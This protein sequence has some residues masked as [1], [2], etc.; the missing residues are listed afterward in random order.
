MPVRFRPPSRRLSSGR[1][2]GGGATV[3]FPGGVVDHARAG[4]V[5]GRRSASARPRFPPFPASGFDARSG[6]IRRRRRRVRCRCVS[7]PA[8]DRGEDGAEAPMSSD[9]PPWWPAFEREFRAYER[10]SRE[11]AGMSTS[12]RLALTCGAALLALWIIARFIELR[13]TL[14]RRRARPRRRGLRP[15]DASCCPPLWPRSGRAAS[16]R[17]ST[18]KLFGVALPLFVYAFLSGGWVARAGD[19]PCSADGR[20]RRGRRRGTPARGSRRTSRAG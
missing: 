19:R 4:A 13:P 6:G 1:D 2:W 14:G 18:F 9:P 20:S 10:R 16:R 11:R 15:A 5:P 8:V 7:R 12:L 17:R 3:T